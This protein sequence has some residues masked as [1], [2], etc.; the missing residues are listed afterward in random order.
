MKKL[1]KQ[2][3]G[4]GLVMPQ[5]PNRALLQKEINEIRALFLY[6]RVKSKPFNLLQKVPKRWVFS[7]KRRDLYSLDKTTVILCSSLVLMLNDF[8]KITIEQQIKKTP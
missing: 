5:R 8:V 7:F 1:L 3:K 2:S 4:D 6:L